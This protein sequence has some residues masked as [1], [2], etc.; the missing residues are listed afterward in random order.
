MKNLLLFG[1]FII[2]ISV[3]IRNAVTHFNGVETD[4]GPHRPD[5]L[6]P[7]GNSHRFLTFRNILSKVEQS[8]LIEQA[9]NA[10][11]SQYANLNDAVTENRTT[12]FGI[13]KNEDGKCGWVRI[14]QK[15]GLCHIQ[16][17][18]D[19]GSAAA[20]QGGYRKRYESLEH[21]SARNSY[22]RQTF[23]YL[24]DEDTKLSL[25][26]RF[27][28]NDVILETAQAY[29]GEGKIVSPQIVY[30]NVYLPGQELLVHTDTPFFRG[31]DRF[32]APQWLLA[33]M[34]HSRLFDDYLLQVVTGVTFWSDV[35]GGGFVFY[36]N[37]TREPAEVAPVVKNTGIMTNTDRV[38]HGVDTVGTDH[39]NIPPLKR[40]YHFGDVDAQ[41]SKA[42]GR[43]VWE[44][45]KP[46]GD[47]L[48]TYDWD[49]FRYSVSWKG[50]CFDEEE[51]AEYENHT[52]DL[53]LDAAVQKLKD[54]L[55]NERGRSRE[56]LVHPDGFAKALYT[57]LLKPAFYDIREQ[58]NYCI[59]CENILK[60]K[61]SDWVATICPF[62]NYQLLGC[63]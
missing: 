6:A 59:L 58:T 24:N 27:L 57:E 60:T 51:L 63:V 23:S 30:A 36:P 7:E 26:E 55:V 44:L 19:A 32:K 2:L 29:C 10:V 46:N 45:K 3:T 31:L 34:H 47:V 21:F 37:G 43:D 39:S 14:P 56:S 22:F 4:W 18:F 15:D 61:A 33:A 9:K 38:V 40:M 35:E 49:T 13:P 50:F 28:H 54:F 62:L 16:N 42:A 1:G 25:A 41:L 8:E 52:N 53:D 20:M 48:G 5:T 17:R 11:F 12:G